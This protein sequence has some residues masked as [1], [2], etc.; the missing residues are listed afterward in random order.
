MHESTSSSYHQF[1]NATSRTWLSRKSKGPTDLMNNVSI[2]RSNDIDA[3][4]RARKK[5]H[6]VIVA[7]KDTH[8]WMHV[9][10]RV[11][12]KNK[13]DR[14]EATEYSDWCNHFHCSDGWHAFDERQ[15]SVCVLHLNSFRLKEYMCRCMWRRR[16]Q[17]SR[18]H[19]TP[20]VT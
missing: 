16:W 7:I 19:R 11:A 6:L 9:H 13:V 3:S 4:Y 15:S 8:I 10:V 20:R 5:F 12:R 14:R 1:I 18:D 2:S 17:S